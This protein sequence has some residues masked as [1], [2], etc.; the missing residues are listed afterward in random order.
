[1]R[2]M[3]CASVLSLAVITGTGVVAVGAAATPAYAEG[4]CPTGHAESGSFGG[5]MACVHVKTGKVIFVEM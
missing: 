5:H 1:M 4:V 2:R 3:I